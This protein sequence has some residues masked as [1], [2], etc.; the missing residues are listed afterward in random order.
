MTDR[1]SLAMGKRIKRFMRKEYLYLMLL[2]LLC[3]GGI[4]LFGFSTDSYTTFM[5]PDHLYDWMINSNG[6]VLIGFM[7]KVW[8]VLGLS[9]RVFYT[10]NFVFFLVFIFIACCFVNKLLREFV[11]SEI[12]SITLSFITIANFFIVEYLCFLEKAGFALSILLSCIAAYF[13]VE[14]LKADKRKVL[15]L[16][17]SHF[18]LNLSALTYQAVVSLFIALTV[19]FAFKY[20]KNFTS[21]I[22]NLALIAAMYAVSVAIAFDVLL[23]AG[24]VR[25]GISVGIWQGIETITQSYVYICATGI[26][27]MPKWFYL[28]SVVL[29]G[30]L[31]VIGIFTR[32]RK[33][34]R[35]MSLINYLMLNIIIPL[36]AL[37]TVFS[38]GWALTPRVVYTAGALPGVLIINYFVNVASGSESKVCITDIL[39]KLISVYC[40]LVIVLQF[41]IFSKIFI[42]KYQNDALDRYRI[43][44]VADRISEYTEDTGIE[45][46][47]ICFYYD[48]NP[49]G[50]QYPL[51]F[52]FKD[53]TASSFT[54]EWSQLNAVNY[55]T[56][57][58]YEEAE[59]D[60][61]LA[62]YFHSVDWDVYNDD[63]L[64]F[65]G[66]TLHICVY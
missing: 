29:L 56:G 27:I 1:S 38:S 25:N 65:D 35:L 13:M 6:R 5:S 40:V 24:S 53:M 66:D 15:F 12:L 20:M 39:R 33:E 3:F 57:G 36:A 14:F 46:K 32:Y 52:F 63:Q 10:L 2:E 47:K 7:Y 41:F 48:A 37:I 8:N 42:A 50:E 49:S 60:T 44:M 11:T 55:Y 26:R 19:P 23:A 59:K 16:I 22:I 54:R 17:L 9:D 45:V 43:E 34:E 4:C 61:E 58:N 30:I 51:V 21:Y 31:N 18:F 64:V 28:C 62:E